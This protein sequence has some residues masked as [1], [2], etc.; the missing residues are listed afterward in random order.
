MGAPAPLNTTRY[1]GPGAS[2]YFG[3]KTSAPFSTEYEPTS[4]GILSV[5]GPAPAYTAKTDAQPADGARSEDAGRPT[6]LNAP[7]SSWME[8]A[9]A[10][11]VD[12]RATRARRATRTRRLST[13][14]ERRK[15]VVS[16]VVER[17]MS[18]LRQGNRPDA[19]RAD[20]RPEPAAAGRRQDH[21]VGG[22]ERGEMSDVRQC[23]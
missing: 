17:L 21:H 3:R 16:S 4:G 7:A 15:G 20:D 18:M 2:G 1:R 14:E 5:P 8:T 6:T 22:V 23:R 10:A 11:A 12:A 19:H 9:C 13:T